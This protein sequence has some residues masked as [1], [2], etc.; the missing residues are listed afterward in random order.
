VKSEE[1]FWEKLNGTNI[2]QINSMVEIKEKTYLIAANGIYKTTDEGKNWFQ[3]YIGNYFKKIICS[4]KGVIAAI[5]SDWFHFDGC[6]DKVIISKDEGK[7]WD[8]IYK[9]NTKMDYCITQLSFNGND[10]LYFIELKDRYIISDST[11]I[12]FYSKDYG[13]TLLEFK[14]PVFDSSKY[15]YLG[16][17]D[18]FISTNNNLY[19]SFTN[20]Y[21]GNSDADAFLFNSN[22]KGKNWRKLTDF[23]RSYK[24]V[25]TLD[26]KTV[27]VNYDINGGWWDGHL[28]KSE[29]SCKTWN[30]FEVPFS[31]DKFVVDSNNIYALEIGPHT[32]YN[33][34]N[35]FY[36][37]SDFGETWE[38]VTLDQEYFY[39]DLF[40]DSKK[41]LFLMTRNGLIHYNTKTKEY[42]NRSKG[43]TFSESTNMAFT[44]DG[45]IFSTSL[46]GVHKSTDDG[47]SWTSCGLDTIRLTSIFITKND[48]IYVSSGRTHINP[49]GEERA[50]YRSTDKGLTWVMKAN[51]CIDD[52]IELDNGEIWASVIKSTDNGET[53]IN[54]DKLTELPLFF[55]QNRLGEIL[56]VFNKL[57][58]YKSKDNGNTFKKVSDQMPTTI[59]FHPYT[60]YCISD[61]GYSTDNG[62]T[63]NNNYKII[64]YGTHDSLYN[65]I[66]VDYFKE[67]KINYLKNNFSETMDIRSG[68]DTIC[69]RYE[70]KT[71]PNGYIYLMTAGAG[72]FRSR[73]K[74]VSVKEQELILSNNL[75][76][77]NPASEYIEIRQPSEGL[78]PSEGYNIQI[79]NIFGEKNPTLALPIGA[80]IGKVL[81]NG[82]DLGGV[83]RID[84]SNLPAGVYFIKIGDKF[85]KFV[86]L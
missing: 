10:E 41:N 69:H 68:M 25:F 49:T 65:F 40:L 81:P 30:T 1:P 17:C 57:G 7:T 16:I 85:E 22:N 6:Y 21:N 2:G 37:S 29:D 73:Q 80:G 72:I 27:Y 20:Y 46:D 78:K 66:N 39:T 28:A 31:I 59:E 13:K 56:I 4:K 11:Y 86:K 38:K 79:F 43:Y 52:L 55:K 23:G 3:V 32:D 51:W 19:L 45:T 75:I 60:D 15:N 67:D 18:F 62:D 61:F 84:I 74:Y 58:L 47:I 5:A 82:E 26:E 44:K 70:I 83:L 14:I 8:E 12:I 71:A 33:H 54:N 48:N 76:S 36:S 50:F 9:T 24:S 77:P 35:T 42:S 63:W 53:W 64:S 34:Y